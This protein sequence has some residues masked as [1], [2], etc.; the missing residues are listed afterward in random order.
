M[1]NLQE[2]K[3]S[4]QEQ[5]RNLVFINLL[6]FKN[7]NSLFQA[8]YKEDLRKKEAEAED[9]RNLRL[10]SSERH[11]QAN[12]LERVKIFVFYYLPLGYRKVGKVW[13]G[14][15]QEPRLGR[16]WFNTIFF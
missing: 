10:K 6:D 3:T 7:N 15:A 1:E 8:E 2:V 4:Y 16:H 5:R 9:S 12:A 11:R 14:G 13:C